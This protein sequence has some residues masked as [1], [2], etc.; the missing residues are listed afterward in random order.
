MTGCQTQNEF[1]PLCRSPFILVKTREDREDREDPTS[2]YFAT[3]SML[4]N[5]NA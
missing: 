3:L 5:E 4:T 1:E 2:G